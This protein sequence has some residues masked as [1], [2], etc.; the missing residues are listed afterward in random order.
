MSSANSSQL[1][2]IAVFIMVLNSA[3]KISLSNK[4]S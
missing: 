4:A 1:R 2:E 3:L